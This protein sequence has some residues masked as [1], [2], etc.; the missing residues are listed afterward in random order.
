MFGLAGWSRYV[1][2]ESIF[3]VCL[4]LLETIFVL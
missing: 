2:S 1:G 3:N 4:M